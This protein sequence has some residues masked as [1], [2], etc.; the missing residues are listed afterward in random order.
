MQHRHP[1]VHH[2]LEL[3]LRIAHAGGHSHGPHALDSVMHSQAAREKAVV[4]SVLEDIALLDPDHHEVPGHEVR[5]GLDILGRVADHGGL[6]GSAGRGMHP[7]DLLSRNGKE[8]EGIV[9][10]QVLLFGSGQLCQVV[11]AL[12][13]LRSD[14]RLLEFV[15]VKGNVLV[16]LLYNALEPL[17]L[18]LFKL[19]S[20]HELH[21]RLPVIHFH[22]LVNFD[23]LCLCYTVP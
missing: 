23:L 8:A 10:P 15:L 18:Q 17:Q 11:E 16:N 9:V 5:P 1:E 21:F 22:T 13:V 3:P 7:H 6:A 4:H 20:L 14:A 2:D 12:D 19:F